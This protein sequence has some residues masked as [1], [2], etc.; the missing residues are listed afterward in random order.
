MWRALLG[1]LLVGQLVCSS[2]A[3][4]MAIDLGSEYLKVCLIKGSRTPISIVV[5]EMSRRKSPALVGLVGEDRVVGEEAFS[6]GIRYPDRI[7]SR[8]RDMLGRSKEDPE[9]ANLLE[10]HRLPYVLVNHPERKTAMLQLNATATLMAEELQVCGSQWVSPGE[11][12]TWGT[13]HPMWVRMRLHAR[14]PEGAAAP[15]QPHH[16]ACRVHAGAG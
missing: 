2:H 5:N 8:V 11:P 15:L 12:T 6:L 7:I 9:L 10:E 13:P 3:Q 1:V 14:L 4:L 16:A